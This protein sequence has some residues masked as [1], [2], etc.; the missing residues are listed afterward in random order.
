MRMRGSRF[1]VRRFYAIRSEAWVRV[2]SNGTVGL[3]GRLLMGWMQVSIPPVL[4]S[5]S[6]KL[7]WKP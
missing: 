1:R 5:L 2:T 6:D 7:Q 4:E 3:L